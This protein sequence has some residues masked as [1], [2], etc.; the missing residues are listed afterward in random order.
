MT[1]VAE[2]F[3]NEKLAAHWQVDETDESFKRLLYHL[4]VKTNFKPYFEIAM[5]KVFV[6]DSDLT[7]IIK[8]KGAITAA[9]IGA[10]VAWT[11]AM[12]AKNPNVKEVYSVEPSQ[13]RLQHGKYVIKHF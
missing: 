10:G 3:V 12:L 11:S 6:P 5:N 9:D 8:Q 7:S 1:K 2:R 4:E 13:N